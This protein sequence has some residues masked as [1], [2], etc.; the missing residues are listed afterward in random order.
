MELDFWEQRWNLNQIAFH[1]PAVNP[2][3]IKFWPLFNSQFHSQVFIPLCGKSLDLAWLASQQHTVLGVECSEKAI[4]DF[5]KEQ[6]LQSHLS[7]HKTFNVYSG[8]NIKLLQGDFFK[9]DKEILADVSVV[10]D[11]AS[12]IAMPETKRQQYVTL[13]GEILPASAEFLL[14]TLDYNQ[15]L[16]PGPPFSV[17]HNE[18]IR[19]FKPRYNV[20]L[21]YE[22]DVLEEHQKF[23][24]RGL[25][26]L[27]ERVYRITN[28][29]K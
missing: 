14:I 2:Y 16:M 15:K 3:L 26:Y 17:S 10:Y 28:F 23:K 22:C 7:Q 4:K 25:N 19:L 9:L 21:L 5:F 13:L 20:E 12:L 6:K 27:I 8:A 24:E 29:C 11:R 1:L 18:V